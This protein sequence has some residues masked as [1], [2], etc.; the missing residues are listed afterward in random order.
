M[1]DYAADQ[2]GAYVQLDDLV[3]M[4]PRASGFSFLPRQPVHSQLAGRHSS[5]LRG[6]G[7]NF[8]E[9]RQYQVGDD[10][11]QIDWKVT[12]R[13]RKTHSRVYTEERERTTLFVVDQRITMF[14]GS[15]KQMKSVTAAQAAALGA[16]RV[17]AQQDRVGAL[18]FNDSDIVEV[19]PQRSHS[20]VMR[21]LHAIVEQNHLLSVKNGTRS[22]PQMFNEAL[23]RCD[24]LAKHDCLV[25][26]ISD[27]VGQNEETRHLITR[28]A[29]HNDVLFGFVHDPLEG[30]LPSAG[31]LVFEDGQYQLEVDTAQTS[32]QDRFREDFASSRNRGRQFLLQRETPVIPLS[33]AEEVTEQIR[34]GLGVRPR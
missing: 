24:R 3:A 12:A 21:I 2:Q 26:I 13:T 11:R 7:L 33:T 28:I 25:C 14:F 8:E 22:N 30:E 10:I 9:I 4:R 27:G 34:R 32:L 17:L 19:R 18:I 6:R 16:W 1:T 15:V 23:R 31:P 20:A 29:R 5:R